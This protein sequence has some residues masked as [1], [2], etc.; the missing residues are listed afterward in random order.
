MYDRAS[1]DAIC[2]FIVQSI[3]NSRIS[4]DCENDQIE[5]IFVDDFPEI[6]I[7]L[8][9]GQSFLIKVEEL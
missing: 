2:Q 8:K 5:S 3:D 1:L 7:V 6:C 9:N 4:L